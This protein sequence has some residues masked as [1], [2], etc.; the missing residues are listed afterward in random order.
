ML[1]RYLSL[2]C[3]MTM[4]MAVH[5]TKVY[6]MLVKMIDDFVVEVVSVQAV[7]EGR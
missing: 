6:R 4:V 5:L 7:L 1:K 3:C 2:I